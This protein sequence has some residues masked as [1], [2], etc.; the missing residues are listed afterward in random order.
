MKSLAH[1][2]DVKRHLHVSKQFD[3]FRDRAMARSIYRSKDH[4][5]IIKRLT[6]RNPETGV[7][8]FPTI[9]ALQCFAAVLGFDH[10]RRIKLDR[11]NVENIEWHTFNNDNF[12]HYIYLIALAETSDMNVL[13]YDIEN[14]ESTDENE[15]MM[16]IFEA[17]ANGGFEIIRNWLDKTPSDP[18]G[19]R[20]LL[21]GMEKAGF[22]KKE[23]ATFSDA[24]F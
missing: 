11:R 2:T 12:T 23:V 14:S 8:V 5:E 4:S 19:D 22:L 1:V 7:A 20:A 18:Y 9:K 15:N 17:Y 16:E 24:N 13:K 3:Y 10:K 21:I 6:D